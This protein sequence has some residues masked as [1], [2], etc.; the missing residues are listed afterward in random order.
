MV[1]LRGQSLAQHVSKHCWS[2]SLNTSRM[3]SERI[4]K[5]CCFTQ[6]VSHNIQQRRQRRRPRHRQWLDD[7]VCARFKSA[8]WTGGKFPYFQGSTW[9]GQ[10]TKRGIPTSFLPT[11]SSL[12]SGALPDPLL[13]GA[14]LHQAS[15]F[16]C[17][18]PDHWHS[19]VVSLI[20]P[21]LNPT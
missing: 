18:L 21:A 16:I 13:P 11:P 17:T 8:L 10:D 4:C 2:Q 19:I 3:P 7:G 1:W 12:R 9:L 6:A 5:T 15:P 20:F 14:T